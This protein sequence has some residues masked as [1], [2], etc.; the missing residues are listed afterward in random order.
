V[1]QKATITDINVSE[2]KKDFVKLNEQVKELAKLNEEVKQLHSPGPAPYK[3][4]IMKTSAA[5]ANQCVVRAPKGFINGWTARARAQVFNQKVVAKFRLLD[6]HLSLPEATGLVQIGG[7]AGYDT[8][9]WLVFFNSANDVN[10]LFAYKTQIKETCP[11]VYVMPS[12]TKEERSKQKL[13]RAGARLFVNGQ[14]SSK[15]WR[16][17]FVENLKVLITGPANAVRYVIIDENGAARVV[18]EGEVKVKK[19]KGGRGIDG[20]KA[21]GSGGQNV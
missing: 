19:E 8:D 3:D 10:K 2:M 17:R 20:M 11:D 4:A 14:G 9:L 12:L 21:G 16:Y 5:T 1:S 7:K 13:L 6:G 15:A 18:T